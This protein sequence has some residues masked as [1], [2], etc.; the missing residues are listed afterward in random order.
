VQYKII[1]ARQLKSMVDSKDDYVFLDARSKDEFANKSKNSWQNIGHLANAINI[2]A[3]DLEKQIT[4]IEKYRTSAVIIYGFGNSAFAYE[5]ANI[6]AAKG[7]TNVNV[8]NGGI[9]NVGW[10]AAN[11]K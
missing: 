2:P 3:S 7:F 5:A 10:T 11:I 9:F 4:D 1:S 8:L 6:L